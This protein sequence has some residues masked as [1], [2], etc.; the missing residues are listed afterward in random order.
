MCLFTFKQIVPLLMEQDEVI[1]YEEALKVDLAWGAGMLCA[2][3]EY[4]AFKSATNSNCNVS[5]PL[6]K[7]LPIATAICK[8]LAFKGAPNRNCNV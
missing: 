4:S 6:S 1:T 2:G 8:Y 3:P 7:R 5:T